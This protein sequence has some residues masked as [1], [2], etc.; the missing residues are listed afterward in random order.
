[1]QDPT[2]SLAAMRSQMAQ[3]GRIL[4][5][6]RVAER[7]TSSAD[8]MHKQAEHELQGGWRKENVKAGVRGEAGAKKATPHRLA[9]S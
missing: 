3:A 8:L 2:G 7:E 4:A 9:S 5:A 1:M 6:G